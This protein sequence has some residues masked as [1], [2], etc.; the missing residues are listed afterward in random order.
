M[1]TR[2]A[3]LRAN[4]QKKVIPKKR[5]T[6]GR[7]VAFRR[8]RTL[9]VR[10]LRAKLVRVVRTA[11]KLT[12]AT[13]AVTTV[14]TVS[15][16]VARTALY[17]ARLRLSF[18]KKSLNQNYYR[19]KRK[20]VRVQ[21]LKRKKLV[22]RR[23]ARR[24]LV[25]RR[26]RR[27]RRNTTRLSGEIGKTFRRKLGKNTLR[28]LPFRSLRA[29]N[30]L[31]RTLVLRFPSIGKKATSSLMLSFRKSGGRARSSRRTMAAPR[32]NAAY[33]ARRKQTFN[34]LRTKRMKTSTPLAKAATSIRENRRR[35]ARARRK[36]YRRLAKLGKKGHGR[37]K[38]RR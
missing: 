5:R 16:R 21:K 17:A 38:R 35:G 20:K 10:A 8:F 19:P 32:R 24:N 14:A 23:A 1:T 27:I 9:R 7:S 18:R 4:K 12:S 2:L 28:R 6:L 36:Y 37:K 15:E 26:L 30:R 25:R 29:G 13:A 33:S 34:H 31:N 22:R 3:R 11:R